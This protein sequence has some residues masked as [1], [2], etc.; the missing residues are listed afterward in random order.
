LLTTSYLTYLLRTACEVPSVHIEHLEIPSSLNPIGVRGAGELSTIGAPA[1]VA[2]AIE[3]AL[4]SFG[5]RTREFSLTQ[6][7]I[8]QLVSD[9]TS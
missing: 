3:D 2:N 1:V 6:D 8:W 5:V 9:A 4:L 7:R